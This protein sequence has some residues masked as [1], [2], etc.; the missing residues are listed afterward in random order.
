MNKFT[1]LLIA[2]TSLSTAQVSENLNY[3]FK[4][5]TVVKTDVK[6]KYI[7]VS[8]P[9]SNGKAMTSRE[10]ALLL[11]TTRP[12]C[13]TKDRLFY[14]YEML[15]EDDSYYNKSSKAVKLN[16]LASI[17]T[18]FKFIIELEEDDITSKTSKN[19]DSLICSSNNASQYRNN[20]KSVEKH[21][22]IK[23]IGDVSINPPF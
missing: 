11:D 14:K 19:I 5:F 8:V 15:G 16:S 2:F 22:V 9:L 12:V 3:N 18:N 21:G 6:N 13:Y 20:T 7:G 23:Y 1:L 17:R 10:F 4:Y